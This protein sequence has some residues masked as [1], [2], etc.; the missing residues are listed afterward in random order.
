MTYMVT[1]DGRSIGLTDD[2]HEAHQIISDWKRDYN[3]VY[4]IKTMPNESRKRMQEQR[5]R[6]GF[7]TW[8]RVI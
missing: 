8:Q 5:E 2:L 6:M 3:G 1:C 4:S 7:Y